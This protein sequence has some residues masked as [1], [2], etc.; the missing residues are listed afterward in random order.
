MLV[1]ASLKSY[2]LI[3]PKVV[4]TVNGINLLTNIKNNP[5]NMNKNINPT[6][7]DLVSAKKILHLLNFCTSFILI[8]IFAPLFT[9]SASQI[10][11]WRRLIISFLLL[12]LV[13]VPSHHLICVQLP[14]PSKISQ[15][16]HPSRGDLCVSVLT[17]R[18][19]SI[20]KKLQ[21]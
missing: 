18:T 5:N 20:D 13:W 2:S 6:V 17:E 19:E 3:R 10:I 4:K 12:I 7:K 14:I 16:Y 21:L 8:R 15:I 1:N 9:V 11:S